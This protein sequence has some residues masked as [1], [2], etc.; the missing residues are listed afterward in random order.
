MREAEQERLGLIEMRLDADRERILACEQ[1]FNIMQQNSTP[2]AK[3]FY[4]KVGDFVL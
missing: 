3:L 1:R 4:G 2:L